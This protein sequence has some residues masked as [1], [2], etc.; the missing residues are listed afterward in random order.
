MFQAAAPTLSTVCAKVAPTAFWVALGTAAPVS[1]PALLSGLAGFLWSVWCGVFAILTRAC[2]LQSVASRWAHLRVH[3]HVYILETSLACIA[4]YSHGYIS[5][6]IL[7]ERDRRGRRHW[8]RASAALD[9][10][11]LVVKPMHYSACGPGGTA[12]GCGLLCAALVGTARCTLL[13]QR[14]HESCKEPCCHYSVR[15]AQAIGCLC[16]PG[17]LRAGRLHCL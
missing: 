11:P 10:G 6:C 4:V 8:Y 16:R 15:S 9:Q 5:S 12:T 3:M 13:C 17:G 2:S 14:L 7:Y 1:N